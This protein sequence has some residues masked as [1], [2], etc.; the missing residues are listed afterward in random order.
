[1]QPDPSSVRTAAPRWFVL[2]LGVSAHLA[3]IAH[4][5]AVIAAVVFLAVTF[6]PS[7]WLL[8]VLLFGVLFIVARPPRR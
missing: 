4:P 5:F 6:G 7:W 3:A 2:F 1:M 8:I